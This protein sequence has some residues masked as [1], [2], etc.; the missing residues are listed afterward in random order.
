MAITNVSMGEN[1]AL[2]LTPPT[3]CPKKGS[4][5]TGGGVPF[6]I[7]PCLRQAV[8]AKSWPP[9]ISTYGHLE[10]VDGRS[11]SPQPDQSD[12]LLQVGLLAASSPMGGGYPTI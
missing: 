7:G 11:L 4:W 1:Q 5:L 6:H 3:A 8:V 9:R 12:G 2:G 10:C